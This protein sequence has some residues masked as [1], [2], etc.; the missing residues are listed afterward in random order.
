MAQRF[1]GETTRFQLR[2]Q[3][4]GLLCGKRVLLQR[5]EAQVPQSPGG[6]QSA[7]DFSGWLTLKESEPFPQKGKTGTAG[8]LERSFKHVHSWYG[9]AKN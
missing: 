5:E 4:P 3:I 6:N 7:S 9:L 2:A 1:G 8:Q